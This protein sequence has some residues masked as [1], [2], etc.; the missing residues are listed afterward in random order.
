MSNEL[1]QNSPQGVCPKCSAP[2]KPE[3]YFCS[4]CTEAWR[5]PSQGLETTPEPVWDA[6]TRI[7][8]RASGAYEACFI[9][10]FASLFGLIVH[11]LLGSQNSY[12]P[13]ETI[14][15]SVSMGIASLWII[16]RNFDI[17]KN[18]IRFD[19]LISPWFLLSAVI[20]APM[21]A[22]NHYYHGFLLKETSVM[23]DSS[24]YLLAD[25]SSWLAIIFICVFPAVFEELV[26][27]SY[28]YPLL[29]RALTLVWAA[30]ISSV[31]FASLHFSFWS[32]PYHFML[33]LLL[34]F[35]ASK[36]RS[37]LPCIILHFVH[38]YVVLFLLPR[39]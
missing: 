9:Y 26:F 4:N 22:V 10:L 1:T 39:T 29:N 7:R 2:L 35:T 36:C 18:S 28:V 8:L 16:Y 27:R 20:L 3:I 25:E 19:G 17:I 11:K 14:L 6:E 24:V 38:N 31:L 13:L 32:W 12:D 37:V 15:V 5:N 21:L 34:A 30:V 33:G 23:M